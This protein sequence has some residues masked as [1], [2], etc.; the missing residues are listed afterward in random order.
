MTCDPSRFPVSR[1]ATTRPK[2]MPSPAPIPRITA[3]ASRSAARGEFARRPERAATAVDAPR[4]VV[5]ELADPPPDFL[6]GELEGYAF[7]K[8]FQDAGI[9]GFAVS[10]LRAYR[11]GM[12]VAT[13]PTFTMRYRINTTMKGGLLKRLLQPFWLSIACVGHPIADYGVIDGEVS[14]EVLEAFN[15]HL[16]RRAAI[17]SYKDFPPTLPLEG[18]AMEPGLPVAALE[19]EGDYWSGLK[20]HVRSDFRRRLRKAEA[21]RIEF[22]DGFPSEL[23]DRIYELYLNVHRR[24]EFSFETLN[25]PFFELVGPF[26]KYALYWEGDTLIGFCLLMCKGKRMHYK[27]L[28]MDYERGRRHG[29]YFIMSLSHI[30][31][32]LRDGYTVYQTGSTTYEF[33]QRLGSTLHP[34]Y[35]YYRHRNRV[36][37]WALCRFM[38]RLSVKPEQLSRTDSLA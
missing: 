7:Y 21:L 18:F 16:L 4:V 27:Y 34:V 29:L 9:D 17:V 20:Q 28:G 25:K 36:I 15:R 12:P 2:D 6:D 13:A 3:T 26:S 38:E 19:I 10:Y 24:G 14:A 22:R 30:E 35:L 1:N 31:M 37:N 8:A 11:S 32:C 5:E 23:G 33:K